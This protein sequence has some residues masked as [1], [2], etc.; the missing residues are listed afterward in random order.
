MGRYTKKDQIWH[1]KEV[2]EMRFEGLEYHQGASFI[3]ER[4]ETSDSCAQILI[5]GSSFIAFSIPFSFLF[6]PFTFLF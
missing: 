1:E 5:F 6:N 3:Y 2:R 4:V